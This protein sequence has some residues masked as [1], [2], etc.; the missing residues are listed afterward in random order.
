[1]KTLSLKFVSGL[2]TLFLVAGAILLAGCSR[3]LTKGDIQDN[4]EDAREATLEAKAK[5]QEAVNAR[6]QFYE[7]YKLTRVSALED[8]IKQIEKRID[9]LQKT[10]KGS[11]NTAAV[12]DMESAIGELEAEK[13]Q[14]NRKIAD[15]QTLKEQDWTQSSATID[16]A[17]NL[18]QAELDKLSQSL[19]GYAE[20]DD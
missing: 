18:I 17:V 7:D 14:I 2:V 20:I 19:D 16:S 8:R 13:E 10:A 3:T 1:M 5:S 12:N 9:D 15:V 4:L 6:E 11:S